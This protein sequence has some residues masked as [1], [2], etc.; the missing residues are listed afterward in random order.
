MPR[1]APLLLT[2]AEMS[3]S[4]QPLPDRNTGQILRT[5]VPV[6]PLVRTHHHRVAEVAVGRVLRL[7]GTA[8]ETEPRCGERH[9]RRHFV[10]VLPTFAQPDVVVQM[11]HPVNPDQSQDLKVTT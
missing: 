4:P 7:V 9:P 2:N 10:V 1:V 6:T 11:F 3:F 5:P 8:G